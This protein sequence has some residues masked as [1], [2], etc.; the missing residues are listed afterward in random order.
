M[1]ESIIIFLLAL[2][3][4]NGQLQL[5]LNFPVEKIVDHDI[6]G[7]VI[8]FIFDPDDSEAIAHERSAVKK[9]HRFQHTQ[10]GV[11]AALE[12]RSHQ[13][14]HPENKQIYILITLLGQYVLSC[15]EQ[16]MDK[17]I[18]VTQHQRGQNRIYFRRYCSCLSVPVYA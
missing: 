15:F 6:V 13:I 1:T 14:A 10:E 4:L 2:R 11:L 16:V 18:G 8:Q 3:L 5:A 17:H 7:R 12:F 9:V